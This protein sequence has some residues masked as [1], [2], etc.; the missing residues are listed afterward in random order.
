MAASTLYSTGL[1]LGFQANWNQGLPGTRPM[2][3][4]SGGTTADHPC[5]QTS[6][7]DD[8]NRELASNAACPTGF[9]K[10]IDTFTESNS[11]A[12]AP[13]GPILYG[14]SN[15]TIYNSGFY[16]ATVRYRSLATPSGSVGP[17][18]NFQFATSSGA[19]ASN[20][21]Y[22][23]N[24][25]Q[26]GN[27]TYESMVYVYGPQALYLKSYVTGQWPPS[28]SSNQLAYIDNVSVVFERMNN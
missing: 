12:S 10:T 7:T 25:Y 18:W 16:K 28:V 21:I 1:V 4:F 24:C 26:Q 23:T 27:P 14:Y 9:Y 5:A 22:D 13:N 19:A 2:V 3:V 20:S 17:T 6:W 11:Y 8:P 15:M